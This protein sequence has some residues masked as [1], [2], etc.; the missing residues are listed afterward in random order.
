[1]IRSG[2]V[3]EDDDGFMSP[4]DR[5]FARLADRQPDHIA[6]KYYRNYRSGSGK[7]S[8][9]HSDNPLWPDWKNSTLDSL[10]AITQSD[11]MEL[12]RLGEKKD[13]HLCGY[14]R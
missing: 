3:K 5:L 8:E 6:L 2:E 12:D 10:A 7:T 13:R 9:I 14:S 1:M 4:L 11:E